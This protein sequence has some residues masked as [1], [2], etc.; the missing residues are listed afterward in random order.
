MH[1]RRFDW[2]ALMG[3]RSPDAN[4]SMRSNGSKYWIGLKTK[5]IK[6][7]FVTNIVWQQHRVF[8]FYGWIRFQT[9]TFL[10]F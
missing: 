3:R 9:I 4:E 8:T 5:Q 6:C 10:L 2:Q 1:S 7:F